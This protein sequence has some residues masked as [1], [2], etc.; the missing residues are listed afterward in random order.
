MLNCV[1]LFSEKDVT[2]R[3]A[4]VGQP[5]CSSWQSDAEELISDKDDVNRINVEVFF[6]DL[7]S[8]DISTAQAGNTWKGVRRAAHH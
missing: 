5:S 2:E 7:S 3:T 8:L 1:R 6:G 4:N